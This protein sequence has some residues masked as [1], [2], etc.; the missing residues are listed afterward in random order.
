MDTLSLIL[1][2]MR[3]QGGVFVHVDL[4]APW[5]LGLHTPGLASFH[6]MTSGQAWLVRDG[7]APVCMQQGD[8]LIL[9]S[10]EPHLI[11]D[12]PRGPVAHAIDLLD[13]IARRPGEELDIGG[14]GE[15]AT[16]VSGHSRY[17]VIMGAPLIAALPPL[18]HIRSQGALPPLWLA[19]GLQFLEQEIRSRR[20]A[21][22]AVVNRLGDI[23]LIQCVRDY[24]EALPEGSGNWLAALR[25][26]A[27]SAA[28]GQLHRQPERS[29]SVSELA[30]IAHLSRSAFADRFTQALGMPPLAYL[31]Q[32]RMRLA[33]RQ[34]STSSLP[35]NRI[36]SLVGYASEAAFS[37]AFKREYG[38]SPSAYRELPALARA[39]P[40]PPA[41]D[42]AGSPDDPPDAQN[43][44]PA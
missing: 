31:T 38:C 39:T 9:P 7:H 16:L 18:L 34:L 44:Y 36:A 17:D 35:V 14:G 8:V 5:A 13:E 43:V 6:I 21:Q 2:D 15:A 29:W 33:A 40:E 41:P 22:Q 10:G 32:H 25:D 30:E 11:Q 37:Q 42:E 3:L 4:T 27:L 24:L 20:P 26:K 23:V 28:L 12:Q 1:D 19:I